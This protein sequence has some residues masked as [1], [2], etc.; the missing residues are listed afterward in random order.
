MNRYRQRGFSL[1]E[2]MV[3]LVIGLFV[4]AGVGSVY[5]TGKRSYQARDGLSLLQENGRTAITVIERMV[6]RAGYPMFADL[7]PVLHASTQLWTLYTE[8]GESAS[9]ELGIVLSADGGVGNSDIL[10]V[11]YQPAGDAAWRDGED[12]V[13][14]KSKIDGR[15]IST[16]FVEGGRLKCRGSGK[17]TAEPL[18]DNVVAMQVEYGE[19]LDNDGFADKYVNARNVG[20]WTEIVAI[21]VA[22]LVHS[23]EDVLDAPV[24]GKQTFTLAGEEVTVES[25]NDKKLY[26]VFQTTVPLRNRM[27]IL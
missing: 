3:S 1:V 27:E 14:N 20:E 23:G 26:R 12:C 10:T 9:G 8:E 22:L 15:V 17:K 2:L 21:R 4:L 7:Q 25:R 24:N 19:D 13:G 5:I 18:V 6:V 16:F 11:Q